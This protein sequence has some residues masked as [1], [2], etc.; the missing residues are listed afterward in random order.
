MKRILLWTIV[1]F[2][3]I[4]IAG[5]ALA[6]RQYFQILESGFEEKS[7]CNIS[8]FV[9]CDAAYA[10]THARFLGIPVSALGL[11]FYLGTALLALSILFKEKAV[12]EVTTLGWLM[13]LT[14]F[15]MTLYKA[16]VSFFVLEVLCLICAAMY[17]VNIVLLLA[18]SLLVKKNFSFRG[19]FQALGVAAL[20]VFG[21]AWLGTD[22]Y[23]NAVL[24]ER[25]VPAT[26]EEILQFHYRQSE[27][28]FEADPANPVW[29]NPNAKVTLVDFSDLQ[30]PFCKK[31]AFHLKP[32]LIEFKDRVRLFY[33]HYP[34][35]KSCN[36][37]VQFAGHD[38]ACLAAQAA[39][40]AERRGDF[41]GYHDDLFRNQKQLGEKLFVQLAGTRGWN[42]QE[43]SE[44]LNAPETIAQVKKDIEAATQIHVTST[45]TILLNNRQV[46]YW[47]DPDILRALV[48]EEI[49]RRY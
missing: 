23:Q 11:V 20:L 34:L 21:L 14:G 3:L 10:S 43:F 42:E 46:K 40:C 28:L 39:V 26:P 6:T 25:K 5:A 15:A 8:A 45:P 36:E 41:W 30:C 24:K 48:K 17:A 9:N 31:A 38:Q 22:Q 19:P 35:D 4:G 49:K 33:Y 32:V 27:Y 7:F 37:N 18:W 47:T 2:S 13:S 1:V 12:R 16:Y 44:C 29:G